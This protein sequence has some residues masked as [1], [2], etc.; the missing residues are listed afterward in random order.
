M[1][2]QKPLDGGVETPRLPSHRPW[3]QVRSDALKAVI[4]CAA[5]VYIS[6]AQMAENPLRT[7]I[8][9]VV[10]LILPQTDGSFMTS[11]IAPGLGLGAAQNRSR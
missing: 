6:P 4:K 9:V 7:A 2:M 3:V 1:V 8:G 11:G 10:V 5:G